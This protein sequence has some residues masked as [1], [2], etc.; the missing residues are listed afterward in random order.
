[1][2]EE[3]MAHRS[4]GTARGVVAAALGLA[5]AGAL[6]VPAMAQDDLSGEFTVLTFTGGNVGHMEEAVAAFTA[7]HPGVTGKVNGITN[8]DWRKNAAFVLGAD[9]A[10]DVAF[11]QVDAR[12]YPSLVENGILQPINDVW[13][14]IGLDGLYPQS[15]I[16]QYTAPDGNHYAVNTDIVWA[17]VVYYNKDAFEKAGIDFAGGRV[18]SMDQW[19]DMA[20]KLRAAGYEPL[21]LGGNTF[22]LNHTSDQLLQTAVSP[23]RLQEFF[24]NWRPG[25]TSDAK[26]TDPDFVSVLQTLKDWNDKGVLA[27]GTAATSYEQAD[28]LFL[29]GEAAMVQTGSWGASIYKGQEPGFEIGWLI[30][31]GLGTTPTSY[32]AYAGNGYSIPTTAKRTDIAK[33]FLKFLMSKETES[34]IMPKHGLIPARTDIDPTTLEGVDPLVK[35][36]MATFPE[37]GLSGLW[38]DTVPPDLGEAIDPMLQG[39]LVGTET[40]EGAAQKLQTI[41]EGLQA[42]S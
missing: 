11:V 3:D 9:D 29:S 16:D 12:V 22:P 20:E 32:L 35:E 38:G 17:P 40:P 42:A 25:T 26:Y 34:V 24:T 7:L 30:E 31:P 14:E 39:I 36:M 21:A 8:E 27:E 19:Y 10:P 2:E 23:E 41:L 37:Y 15:T 33:E 18:E 6:A 4:R 28:Q 5:L 13:D 1:M